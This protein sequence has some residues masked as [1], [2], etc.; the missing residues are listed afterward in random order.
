MYI[1]INELYCLFESN[2]LLLIGS[3]VDPIV[4]HGNSVMQQITSTYRYYLTMT[5][6]QW[7]RILEKKIGAVVLV[8]LIFTLLPSSDI[9]TVAAVAAAEAAIEGEEATATASA[10]TQPTEEFFYLCSSGHLS[11]N[12]GNA[13]ESDKSNND[14]NELEEKF[15]TILVNNPSY[16]NSRTNSGETCL[17]LTGIHGNAIVTKLLLE[18]GIADVNIRTTYDKGLR[19]VRS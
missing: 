1:Y 7:T 18:T 10:T 6:L 4:Y 14:T 8:L 17:H 2:S 3:N 19:M 15:R 13:D 11:N 12:N 5:L 9:T 16:V